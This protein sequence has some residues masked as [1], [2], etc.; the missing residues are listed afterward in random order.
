MILTILITLGSLWL[1]LST[2]AFLFAKK[3]FKKYRNFPRIEVPA[4]M[5]PIVRRDFG[6]WDE[7]AILRGCFLRFPLHFFMVASFL[8][9]YGVLG[10]LQKYLKY[11]DSLIELFR[12]KYGR[13]ACTIYCNLIEE[14]DPKEAVTTPI[15]IANHVNWVDFI[16]MGGCLPLAS[17]VAKIEVLNVPVLR[18]IANYLKALYVDRSSVEGRLQTKGLIV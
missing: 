10:S 13:L 17:F 6:K 14:F 5:E 7:G 16:Y 3:T 1:L 12:S 11:P 2:A 18:D 15:I 4:S 9:T 8:V